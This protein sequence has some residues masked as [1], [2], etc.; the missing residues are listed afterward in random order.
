MWDPDAW[1]VRPSYVEP[2]A[3]PGTAPGDYPRVC[4]SISAAWIPYILGALTQLAQPKAWAVAAGALPDL[5]GRVQDLI[6]MIGSAGSCVMTQYGRASILIPAGQASA[7]TPVSFRVAYAAPPIVGVASG[8]GKLHSWFADVTADGF[9]VNLD[10]DT[11][12]VSD[13]SGTV[14]WWAFG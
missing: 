5:L 2:V 14:D 1:D 8:D 4:L 6:A 12:V 10:A 11:S 7:G 13:T 3:D 9:T